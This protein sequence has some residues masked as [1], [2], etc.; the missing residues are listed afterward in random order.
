MRDTTGHAEKEEATASRNSLTEFA[1]KPTQ[2]ERA[3]PPDNSLFSFLG[4]KGSWYTTVLGRALKHAASLCLLRS[5]LSCKR[6]TRQ[7]PHNTE[8]IFPHPD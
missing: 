2:P 5:S 7:V 4:T 6:K 1:A 8:P 3:T